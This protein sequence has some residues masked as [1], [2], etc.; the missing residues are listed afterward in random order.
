MREKSNDA[1][2]RREDKKGNGGRKRRE[3]GRLVMREFEKW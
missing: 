3:N 2:K 1:K